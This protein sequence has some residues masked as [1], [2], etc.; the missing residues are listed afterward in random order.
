MGPSPFLA[1]FLVAMIVL[2]SGP[3]FCRHVALTIY[4]SVVSDLFIFHSSVPSSLCP[5]SWQLPVCFFPRFSDGTSFAS[6][7]NLLSLHFPVHPIICPS[8]SFSICWNIPCLKDAPFYS[9]AATP[10]FNAV[11]NLSFRFSVIVVLCPTVTSFVKCSKPASFVST[12]A[13]L[14]VL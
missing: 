5:L 12:S 2:S 11:G 7:R 13:L 10:Y 8:I 4:I 14:F 9:T 3:F 6:M 1:C